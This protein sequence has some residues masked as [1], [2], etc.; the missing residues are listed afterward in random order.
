MHRSNGVL[1]FFFVQ[2]SSCLILLPI[3][4]LKSYCSTVSQIHKIR[5]SGGKQA[6]VV[7]KILFYWSIVD[8]QCCIAKWFSYIYVYAFF[9]IFFSI[10]VYHRMSAIAPRAIQQV[11]VVVQLLSCAWLCNC[12]DCS[13]PGSCVPGIFQVRI[14]EW[15][16]ISS[17]RGSSWPRDWTCIGRWVL[18]CWATWDFCKDLEFSYIWKSPTFC[19]SLFKV[20]DLWTGI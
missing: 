3:R 6:L 12:T 15:V 17:S 18:Y 11:V 4:F 10:V 20:K 2:V 19:F 8:L 5:I 14:L 7:F 1:F 16:A 13:L 9:L